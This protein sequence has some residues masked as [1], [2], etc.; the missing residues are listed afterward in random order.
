[1]LESKN[2]EIAVRGRGGSVYISADGQGTSD[3]PVIGLTAGVYSNGRW[4][5]N[6]RGTI[7]FSAN[8]VSFDNCNN[9]TGIYAKYK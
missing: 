7:T 2:A 4:N 5:I 3:E 8:T 9:I 6:S 1:V